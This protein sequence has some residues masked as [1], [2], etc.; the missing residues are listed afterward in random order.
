MAPRPPSIQVR[1]SDKALSQLEELKK[2][3]S[4]SMNGAALEAIRFLQDREHHALSEKLLALIPSDKVTRRYPLYVRVDQEDRD[5]IVDAVQRNRV[6]IV[7][8]VELAIQIALACLPE[9][10]SGG[11]R[12]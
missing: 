12:K 3:R 6:T 5:Q 9:R 4:T 10:S 11:S 1:I 8:W 2:K 7:E